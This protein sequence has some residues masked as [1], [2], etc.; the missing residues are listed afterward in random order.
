MIPRELQALEVGQ[1]PDALGNKPHAVVEQ[2]YY[3][4]ARA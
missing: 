1:V 2:V 3:V 4:E